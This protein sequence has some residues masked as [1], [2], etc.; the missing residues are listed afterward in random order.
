MKQIDNPNEYEKLSFQ[1]TKTVL[2]WI[3]RNIKPHKVRNN[4][5]YSKG[6]KRYFERD[7]EA[8]GFPISN[9][10]FKGAMK[11]S[12]YNPVDES[13][14]NWEFYISNRSQAFFPDVSKEGFRITP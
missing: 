8:G 11:A 1:Q 3:S 7:Y 6:I 5:H 10:A 13:C 4:R 9:G 12:G 2:S 14:T